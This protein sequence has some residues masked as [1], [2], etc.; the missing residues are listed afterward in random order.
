MLCF[1]PYAER[2]RPRNRRGK[3]EGNLGRSTLVIHQMRPLLPPL[4]TTRTAVGPCLLN[5][6]RVEGESTGNRVT[7][8]T[9]GPDLKVHLTEGEEQEELPHQSK[10]QGKHRGRSDATNLSQTD[11]EHP[12][13]STTNLGD[14]EKSTLTDLDPVLLGAASPDLDRDLQVQEERRLQVPFHPQGSTGNSTLTRQSVVPEGRFHPLHL[15]IIQT[16][17]QRN[18]HTSLSFFCVHLNIVCTA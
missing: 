16:R 8:L 12:H 2:R 1:S 13:R 9:Q 10:A 7:D 11:Q 14:K 6:P 3:R 17:G 18:I 15:V 5:L 4:A